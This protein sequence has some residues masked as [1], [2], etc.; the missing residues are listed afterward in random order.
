MNRYFFCTLHNGIACDLT[1]GNLNMSVF[2]QGPDTVFNI[3]ITGYQMA[4]RVNRFTLLSSGRDPSTCYRGY[5]GKK[6]QPE[7]LT[8]LASLK[9]DPPSE[10]PANMQFLT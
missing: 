3:A 2:S 10:G 4:A 9:A 8:A 6:S 7:S 1:A 5:S